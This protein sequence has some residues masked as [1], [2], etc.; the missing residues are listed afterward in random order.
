MSS[1]A[2]AEIIVPHV[3][4]GY[5]DLL[6]AIRQLDE[7]GRAK[8]ARVLLE[9]KMDDEMSSLLKE[10]SEAPHHDDINEAEIR[11]EVRAVRESRAR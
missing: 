7:L 3:R 5:D 4:I 8:I 10:L 2:A 9:T 6:A 11:A 1:K